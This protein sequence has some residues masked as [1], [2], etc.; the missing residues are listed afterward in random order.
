MTWIRW[1]TEAPRSEVVAFI[2]HHLGLKVYAAHGLYVAMCLGFAVERPD[3]RI[4]EVTDTALE[5]WAGWD[6]KRGRFAAVI[7]KWCALSP[8]PD[9]LRGW[10]R[11]EAGLRKQRH[12]AARPDGRK[13]REN[14]PRIP[15]KSRAGSAGDSGA[16]D[17]GNGDG[18]VNELQTTHPTA[19]ELVESDRWQALA[20]RLVGVRE[21]WRVHDWLCA[22]PAEVRPLDWV[23]IMLGCLDGMGLAG[24]KPARP[25]HLVAVCRDWGAIQDKALSP[26]FFRRCVETAMSEAAPKALRRGRHQADTRSAEEIIAE[27]ERDR[28]FAKGG[29]A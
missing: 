20:A 8:D 5:S 14:P 22:L 9:M 7:R 21:N 28:Q 15:P 17:G 6:G 2:A 10:H 24:A 12:D 19:P 3:G 18:Y 25:E 29:A 26:R 4:G 13:G 16:K 27:R 1:D 23:E 11:N